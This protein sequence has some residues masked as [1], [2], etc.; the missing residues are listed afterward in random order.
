MP[1][2]VAHPNGTTSHTDQLSTTTDFVVRRAMRMVGAYTST[3]SPRPEQYRD[4]LFSLN[5]M[6]KGWSTECFMW[7]RQFVTVTL[8]AGQNSYTLGPDG[9]PSIDR[10]VHVYTAN[11]K[12]SSGSEVPMIPLTRTDWFVL[13]NKTSNGTPV[14]YYYDAQTINGTLYVWPTPQTGTTDVLVLDVD[15]QLD[16]QADTFNALDFPPQWIDAITYSLAAR[17]AP[18]Y[19]MPLAERQILEAEAGAL[20]NKAATDDRDVASIY[21]G[22]KKQ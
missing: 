20:F 4:A 15:R 10:P 22:V 7:L 14:Q 6:L 3:D 13:P 1:V 17:L 8:V 12:N 18:E 5:C 11:R 9:T 21:F 19:G 16:I 2:Y